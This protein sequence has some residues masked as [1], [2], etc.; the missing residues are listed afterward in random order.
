TASGETFNGLVQI[1]HALYDTRTVKIMYQLFCL[2][3]VFSSV[4]KLHF[5]CSRYLHLR[6][7]VNVTICMSCDG[8]RFLPVFY[9]WFNAFYYNGSTE[10][11]S[12]KDRTDRPVRALPHLFLVILI[13]PCSIR[14]D[15]R[16][17]YGHFV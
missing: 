14:S 9:T 3:S 8:D 17:F 11:C 7:F 2:A 13:H 5:A 4:H 16:T 1:M 6:P 15:R 10:Y 12:V